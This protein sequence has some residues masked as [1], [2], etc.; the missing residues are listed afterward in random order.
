MLVLVGKSY[1]CPW[2]TGS[3]ALTPAELA[4]T[5]IGCNGTHPRKRLPA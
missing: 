4:V 1:R 3:W 2:S 5:V